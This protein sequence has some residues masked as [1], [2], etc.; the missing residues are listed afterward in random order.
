LHDKSPLSKIV[1]VKHVNDL[2]KGST[3][4]TGRNFPAGL[5]KNVIPAPMIWWSPLNNWWNRMTYGA[6]FEKTGKT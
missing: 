3:P 1:G 5:S 4:L 2:G 6:G